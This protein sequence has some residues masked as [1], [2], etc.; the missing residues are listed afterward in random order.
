MIFRG[1]RLL[2]LRNAGASLHVPK[3]VSIVMGAATPKVAEASQASRRTTGT[4]LDAFKCLDNSKRAR[5]HSNVRRI[6]MSE[7]LA[8]CPRRRVG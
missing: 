7:M 5:E 6:L 3:M 2:S 4:W 1:W 8:N